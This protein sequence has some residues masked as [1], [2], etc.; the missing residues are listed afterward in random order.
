MSP[1]QRL[2]I[3]NDVKGKAAQS[4]KVICRICRSR[5]VCVAFRLRYDVCLRDHI[6]FVIVFIVF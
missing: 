2:E 5:D 1:H 3:P 4:E 6:K